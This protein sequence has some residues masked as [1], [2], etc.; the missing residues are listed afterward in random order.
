MYKKALIAI[1]PSKILPNE[2]GVFALRNLPK[3]TVISNKKVVRE[4]LFKLKTYNNLDKIT[5]ERVDGFLGVVYDGFF[6]N[7]DINQMPISWH[8]NH[9]CE[10]NIGY[11]KKSEMITLRCISTNQELLLDYALCNTHPKWELKCRC[12]SKKCRG[13]ITGND[14]KNVDYFKKNLDISCW[15]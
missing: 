5:K 2:I 15:Y 11:N 1:K 8:C 9:S 10:P 12:G 3:G 6:S 7:E 14:W 4:K 13:I